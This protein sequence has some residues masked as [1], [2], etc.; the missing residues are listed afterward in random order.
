MNWFNNLKIGVRLAIGFGALVAALAIVA[1]VGSSALSSAGTTTKGLAQNEVQSTRDIASVVDHA[2]DNRV[3]VAQHLY[4][5]DGDLKAQDA[6][7]RKIA[8]NSQEIDALLA[9]VRPRLESPAAT[10]ALADFTAAYTKFNKRYHDALDISREETVKGVEERDGSRGIYTDE[11]MPMADGVDTKLTGLST[12]VGEQA[13]HEANRAAASA[14]S[15]SRTVIIVAILA[16]LAAAGLGFVITRRI[17]SVVATI[18]DRLQSLEANCASDLAAAIDAAAEG[19][20]TRTV[21]PVT[22]LIDDP[23]ADELGQVADATNGIRNKTVA[24]VESYNRMREKLA[25][26]IGD[27]AGSAGTVSSASQQMASTSEEAGKAVGEIASAVGD[28]A[29]GA[30]R[31]VRAVEQTKRLSEEVTTAT[32]KSAETVRETAAAAAEARDLAHD[33]VERVTEATEAMQSVRDSSRGVT[34][35][36]RELGEKSERI[37]GIVDTITGIAGQTNLLALN[38]AIEAARAGEQ[39]RG[40]AVVAEE[41]RKLAEESQEAASTIASLI[42]EIQADTANAVHKVE[43]GAQRT[44]EGATTVEQ[45]REAFLKIG[46]SVDDMHRRVEEIAAAIAQIAENSTRMQGDMTEVAAVA[47]E[48]SASTEQVSASTEQTSASTQEIAASAQEL[49][50]TASQLEQLVAQFKLAV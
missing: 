42:E 25:D 12:A 36:I 26:L 6:T 11:L 49:A 24:S 10:A 2:G 20:L 32:E 46:G 39:G 34:E 27:V 7:A 44:D 38:A 41:V 31:Q 8:E 28:V 47:E 29:Q 14:S 19:D 5:Q 30:E 33:G 17:K 48:S 50:A 9:K 4:V 37:G 13:D 21:T 16:A 1:L 43:D 40:F 3:L 22:A 35:A 23:A 45:A 18:L 15:S